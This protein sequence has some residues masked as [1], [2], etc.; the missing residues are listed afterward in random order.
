MIGIVMTV[1]AE[2]AAH[3]SRP[4]QRLVEC[5]LIRQSFT[6]IYGW[7]TEGFDTVALEEAKNCERSCHDSRCHKWHCMTA[8]LY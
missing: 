1:E 4:S 6:E 3:W 8:S 7:L 2:G 5:D